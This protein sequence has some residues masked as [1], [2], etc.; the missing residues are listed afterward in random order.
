M[1]IATKIAAYWVMTSVIWY[2]DT[3]VSEEHA[4]SVFRE[5]ESNERLNL[6]IKK[7]VEI[8]DRGLI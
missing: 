6:S 1:A 3:K 5:E 7:G 8:N 2:R 4:A